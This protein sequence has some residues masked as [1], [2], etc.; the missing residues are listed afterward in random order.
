KSKLNFL[1]SEPDSSMGSLKPSVWLSISEL[2]T[3]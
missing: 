3:L 2:F 1:L